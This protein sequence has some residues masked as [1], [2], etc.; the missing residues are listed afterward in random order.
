M[1]NNS[2]STI[3]HLTII[4]HTISTKSRLESGKE[5]SFRLVALYTSFATLQLHRIWPK[6][7]SPP[8]KSQL[9]STP[10]PLPCSLHF[11]GRIFLRALHIKCL[12]L[13]GQFKF[14]TNF[15]SALRLV[16]FEHS[17]PSAL[18]LVFCILCWATLYALLTMKC[19]LGVHAHVKAPMGS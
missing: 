4:S 2:Q 13:F 16:P 12:T 5:G 15:H 17:S 18:P 1:A 8:H 11:V 9:T 3:G 6:F 14:Q 7:S 19:L 10:I